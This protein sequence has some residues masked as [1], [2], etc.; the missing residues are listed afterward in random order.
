[1]HTLDNGVTIDATCDTDILGHFR[2]QCDDKQTRS[3]DDKAFLTIMDSEVDQNQEKSLVAPLPFRS[4]RKRFPDNREQTL[5]CLCSLRKTLD[6]K[7]KIKDYYIQFMQKMLD[8]DQAEFAP[9]L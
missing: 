2:S 8:N 5:K 9:P 4:L 1:M 3:I 6:K 7:P